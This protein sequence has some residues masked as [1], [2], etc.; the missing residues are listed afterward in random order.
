MRLSIRWKLI[1]SIVAPLLIIA[2]VVMWFTFERIN[3]YAVE[4]MQVFV[5]EQARNYAARLDNRFT[6]VAQVAHGTAAAL[7]N[8]DMPD[9]TVLY[10]LLRAHLGRDPLIYGS[11]I[12]FE[13]YRYSPERE[14]YA[15]YVYRQGGGPGSIDISAQAYD[16]TQPEYAWFHRART[17]GSSGWNVPYFDTVAGNV[18]MNTYAVPF[19]RNGDF[20]GVVTVDVALAD[21]D[22]LVDI[23]NEE[24]YPYIIVNADG[25]FL[26][27]PDPDMI[28]KGSVAK[29]AD[30]LANP[31]LQSF[32]DDLLSGESGVVQV[33]EPGLFQSDEIF[34]IFYAP[35][36]TT[37]WAFAMAVPESEILGFLNSQIQRG[38]IGLVVMIVLVILCVL[39]IGTSLTRPLTR[40]NEGVKELARGDLNLEIRGIDSTDEIGELARGFNDMVAQLRRHVHALTRETAARESYESEMQFANQVQA[41]LLPAGT[42]AF[43]EL[44]QF[45][46]YG[47]NRPARHVA[48]DFFDFLMLD[49]QHLMLVIADVSGKGMASALLMAV[50]RTIVRNQARSGKGPA[51]ILCD[52]NRLLIET[53]MQSLYVTM[54]IAC[55]NIDTGDITY[56]NAGHPR[57]FKLCCDD[58]VTKF[59]DTTGTIVGMLEDA[60]YTEATGHLDPGDFLVL[61][62]DGVPDAR[63]PDGRFFGEENFIDLLRICTGKSVKEICEYTVDV[64]VG[65]QANELKDDTTLLVIRRNEVDETA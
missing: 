52:A 45:D 55:Y 63:A 11:A 49:G 9:E 33:R 56:A 15:P 3:R 4:R 28:W 5:T 43:P 58:Q 19:Y 53:N 26:S 7:E 38:V 21:L 14:L 40:L 22:E 39:I 50:T 6:R 12:A 60:E 24:G 48:G 35:I 13:P 2:A 29:N 30:D 36:E 23:G 18:L 61:Y 65:Y 42:L 16:Y 27:H 17:E 32:A 20:T 41:S 1:L 37:G 8:M 34:W 64:L 54:F 51:E 59:G 57:P 46:L 31:L 47:I 10:A 25:Q 62:T 44:P